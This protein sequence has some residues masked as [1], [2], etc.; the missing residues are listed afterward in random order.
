MPGSK[1]QTKR[2]FQKEFDFMTSKVLRKIAPQVIALAGTTMLSGCIVAP[3][4][5]GGA[6]VTTAAVATD[7]RTTGAIVS[8]EVIE[9]RVSYEIEQSMREEKHH[10]TVTSYDGRVLLS[11]EV[12]TADL[13]TRIEDIARKNIDVKSV[14]N[15]VA[16]MEPSSMS[17]R[18]SDSFLATS[19]RTAIIGDANISLNQMKVVT[20][21]G[22]VYLMGFVT[23][24]EAQTAAQKAA[25]ISGVKK[26]VTCFTLATEAEIRERMKA[27]DA[28]ATT[29]ND[30]GQ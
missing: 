5:M 6:A 30:L 4:L 17:T 14:I 3:V 29:S 26:V 1:L 27:I 7:R 9:R 19:V 22:I 2:F 10:V 11:G 21:R 20:E 24:T 8:D 12:G 16:V 28:S 15:E 23:A 25:G 13:R 18:L